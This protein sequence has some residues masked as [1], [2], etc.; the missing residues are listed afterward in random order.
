MVLG[1]FQLT[2]TKGGPHCIFCEYSERVSRKPWNSSFLILKLILFLCRCGDGKSMQW[3]DLVTDNSLQDPQLGL[4]VRF[5]K[6]VLMSQILVHEYLTILDHF[7]VP[8]LCTSVSHQH[9][10]KNVNITFSCN[11]GIPK[12]F[13]YSPIL[14]CSSIWDL[15]YTFPLWIIVPYYRSNSGMR[16]F[17]LWNNFK[18]D[19]YPNFDSMC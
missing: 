11:T 15:K 12:M 13:Q 19:T 5:E 2:P 17:H 18:I 4:F 14:G 1:H 8:V 7:G 16:T 10:L 9:V 3:P 6:S